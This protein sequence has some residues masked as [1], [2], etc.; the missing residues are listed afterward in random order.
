MQADPFNVNNVAEAIIA[1][2]NT[3]FEADFK[4]VD[5]SVI[6]KLIAQLE[7]EGKKYIEQTENAFNSDIDT[8]FKAAVDGVNALTTI[9][10]V[11]KKKLSL[12]YKFY[13]MMAK[14]EVAAALDNIN[15]V[16]TDF[17][18]NVLVSFAQKTS[19]SENDIL[20]NVQNRFNEIQNRIRETLNN[21]VR[22][23]DEHQKLVINILK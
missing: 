20:N 16:I 15:D 8:R 7:T 13:Q 19:S 5:P 9:N 23:D 2:V 3:K 21:F 6:E 12:E 1:K 14:N 11:K 18:K 10:A 4:A 17:E 22:L